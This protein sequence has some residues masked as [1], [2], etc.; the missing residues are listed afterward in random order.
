M[1]GLSISEIIV[2]F[3]TIVVFVGPNQLP[4]FIRDVKKLINYFKGLFNEAKGEYNNFK[5]IVKLDDEIDIDRINEEI[6]EI[7]G[8]DG[9]KYIA[10]SVPQKQN[11]VKKEDGQ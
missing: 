1:F 5:E 4:S 10:Y 11:P 8:D 9:N 7:I 3:L 6:T 2:I